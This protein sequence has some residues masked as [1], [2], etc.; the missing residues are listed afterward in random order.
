MITIS[1]H[2]LKNYNANL[3][4]EYLFQQSDNAFEIIIPRD[5][6][7]PEDI[8]FSLF[9]QYYTAAYAGQQLFN[10][11]ESFACYVPCPEKKKP[12]RFEIEVADIHRLAA[13]LAFIITGYYTN[14]D[15]MIRFNQEA[16][17]YFSDAYEGKT[18]SE[19]WSL[20]HIANKYLGK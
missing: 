6:Y 17:I 4:S 5:Q 13:A 11:S 8:N 9:W 12:F 10:V 18:V 2:D 15:S 14:S 1:I 20:L 16:A 3:I 19:T 7:D